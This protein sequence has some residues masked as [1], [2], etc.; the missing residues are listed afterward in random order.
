M[1]PV[2]REQD[3]AELV[4]LRAV[5]KRTKRAADE[6]QADANRLAH[7]QP[8]RVRK[9]EAKKQAMADRALDGHRIDTGDG[10]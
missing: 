3:L 7:G 5:R 6:R 4:N 10:R 9:L 2:T 1:Y 8:A